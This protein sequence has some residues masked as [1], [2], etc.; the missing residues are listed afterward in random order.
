[1][2]VHSIQ[3][4][5]QFDWMIFCPA[6]QCGHGLAVGRNEGPSWLFNG[7]QERPTFSPSLLVQSVANPPLD[8]ETNDFKRGPDGAYLKGPDGRLLG[9]KDVRCHSI[10][11]DG[12]ISFCTDCTHELAGQNV[13]LPDF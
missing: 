6:C 13:D 5:A 2:K 7:N 8:P 11:T 10:I 9:A 1:M 4:P 3:Q 12:R